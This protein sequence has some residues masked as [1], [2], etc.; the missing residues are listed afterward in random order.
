MS[1]PAPTWPLEPVRQGVQSPWRTSCTTCPPHPR[2]VEMRRAKVRQRPPN[3]PPG[4]AAR[5]RR[6]VPTPAPTGAAAAGCPQAAGG[7]LVRSRCPGDARAVDIHP[8]LTDPVG[9]V[10]AARRRADCSQREMAERAGVSA[11]T[12]GRIEAGALAPSLA[13]LGRILAVADLRLVAVDA[14]G[15]LVLPMGDDRDDLRDA[16]GRRYPSHLDTVLDP[17]DGDWWGDRYGLTAP[18]ETF[19]RDR[20]HRDARRRRSQWEVRVA[21]HRHLPPPPAQPRRRSGH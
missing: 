21:Q 10:R 12:V 5:S 4:P 18:P 8:A 19:H 11:S 13:V 3:S 14:E 17:H 6:G 7:G 20:R 1:L 15:R 16:A 2:C 9:L